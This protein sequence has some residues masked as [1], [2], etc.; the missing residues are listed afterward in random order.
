MRNNLLSEG[1]P[2]TDVAS[3]IF[4]PSLLS[5]CNENNLSL[6]DVNTSLHRVVY[7]CNFLFI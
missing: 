5:S 7:F 2:I 1:N 3:A 4:I 6:F